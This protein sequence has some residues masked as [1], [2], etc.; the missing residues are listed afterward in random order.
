MQT[1]RRVHDRCV[2]AKDE[3]FIVGTL[4][5]SI[6]CLI[7]TK[8]GCFATPIFTENG[9]EIGTIAFKYD[10]N[11][12]LVECPLKHET[13]KNIRL[14]CLAINTTGKAEFLPFICYGN[15]SMLFLRNRGTWDEITKGTQI[16]CLGTR[17]QTTICS[18][19]LS[20]FKIRELVALRQ[21]NERQTRMI[22]GDGSDTHEK[23][24]QASCEDCP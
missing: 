19:K 17:E 7:K 11:G 8:S 20:Y 16:S 24:I 5:Q 18:Q 12:K 1:M 13:S 3:I 14:P 21:P 22:E 2:P 10:E 9:E 23:D 15:D 4:C 6:E